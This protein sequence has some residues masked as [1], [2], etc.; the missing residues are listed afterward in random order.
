ML[1]L[2]WGREVTEALPLGL[3]TRPE[4]VE[5]GS[6]DPFTRSTGARL[7]HVGSFLL[8]QHVPWISSTLRGRAP[9]PS[10]FHR[11]GD[12][13]TYTRHTTAYDRAGC[14]FTREVA[15]LGD[16]RQHTRLA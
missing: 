1:D 4:G 12:L 10:V 14:W 3:Y 5:V 2:S 16:Y 6:Q 13:G 9:G 15:S 11:M 7:D 8:V